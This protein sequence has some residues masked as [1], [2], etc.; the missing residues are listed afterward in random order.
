MVGYIALFFGVC[1]LCSRI[2]LM[3]SVL[4]VL[5]FLCVSGVF[6]ACVFS[7]GVVYA[8]ESVLSITEIMYDAVGGDEGKEFVEVVNTGSGEIDM[9]K[10]KFF[11]RNDRPDRPGGSLVQSQGSTVLLPGE[12]AIIVAKPELFLQQ[13]SFDGVLLDTRNFALLNTG[14][15]VSLEIDDRLLHSVTYTAGDG[16]KGD[17]NSLHIKQDGVVF[18]SEPSPGVV[19]GIVADTFSVS[20]RDVGSG[21]VDTQVM[22]NAQRRDVE[23]DTSSAFVPDMQK[24]AVREE[25]P[26]I[27]VS[28]PS[29][30]FS[31]STTR[32]SV[33]RQRGGQEEV[34]YGLWNFGDGDYTYGTVVEH[35]YLHPG[36]YIVVFQE[37]DENGS[38]GFALQKEIRV[39]FPQVSIERIDDAFV[40]LHNRYP[41]ILDVSGWRIESQGVV[42]DF[43]MRSLVLGQNSIVVPFA[44]PEG[45]D[46]FFVTAGGGQFNGTYISPDVNASGSSVVVAT[47]ANEEQKTDFV[48][49]P[50][51]VSTKESAFL[52]RDAVVER[53]RSSDTTHTDVFVAD[54]VGDQEEKHTGVA[55][56]M[57]VMWVVLLIGIIVIALVPLIF[58]RREKAKRFTHMK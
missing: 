35:A 44:I 56:R 22:S 10:V 51:P 21:V 5:R 29:V 14:A 49:V 26:P 15:T 50:A 3:T 39:L 38:E 40:R 33:V 47:S 58:V 17:G 19:Q 36:A 24:M 42:F 16:A 45:Q 53:E 32:F 27:F 1:V 2:V 37:L 18:V 41:F 11:E 30:V 23:T 34:L 8:A 46:V 48:G 9:T 43:P 25:K 12:V 20:E 7:V 31:A 52:E 55:V 57:I 54:A 4:S 6:M 28:D 13:Y